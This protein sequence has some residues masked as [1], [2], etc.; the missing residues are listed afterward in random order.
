MKRNNVYGLMGLLF[1]VLSACQ[2]VSSTK[3][4]QISPQ[5][6]QAVS[7]QAQKREAID[8]IRNKPVYTGPIQVNINP[9][10]VLPTSQTP[11]KELLFEKA[12]F[13][14]MSLPS[15]PLVFQE[16]FAKGETQRNFAIEQTSERYTLHV[17]KFNAATQVEVNINGTNWI[18]AG[19]FKGHNLEMEIE[20]LLLFAHNSIRV[21]VSGKTSEKAV[22]SLVKGGDAGTLLRRRGK[23]RELN[24]NHASHV[25]QNDVNLFNPFVPNS[26]G[27]L[28]AYHK[29]LEITSPNGQAQRFSGMQV[30]GGSVIRFETGALILGLSDPAAGREVLQ[31]EYGA[32]LSEELDG[33]YKFKLD[34]SQSPVMDTVNLIRISQCSQRSKYRKHDLFIGRGHANSGYLLGFASAF[35]RV[36]DSFR[37]E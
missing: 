3:P 10:L 16:T 2:S 31:N 13:K 27:D 36:S 15:G 8:K 30:N 32:T 35:S 5:P 14:L 25:R 6:L 7:N 20:S 37:I 28:S 34:L 22:V 11:H 1:S 33:L 17:K 9:S 21:R 29:D 12:D 18:K 4:Q 19:D 24:E 23:L 26:L